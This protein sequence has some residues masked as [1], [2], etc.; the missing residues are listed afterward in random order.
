MIQ[1]V[2]VSEFIQLIN[3][4]VAGEFIVE[5]EVT[6]YKISQNKWIFFNL[7]DEVSCLSCFST[8]FTLKTPLEEGMK[9]R[10]LG[11]PKVHD[12]SGRFSF[13]VQKVELLGEGALQRA[14]L[15]LKQK[16]SS[17]GL[18]DKTRKRPLPPIPER[19]GVIASGDSAA[20]GD[21]KRILSNR[22]GGVEVILRHVA[23]QG[24]SAVREIV[25]AFKDF[26]TSKTMCDVL[27]LIRG[28][29]SLE[30]LMAFNSEE[31][32]RAIYSSRIPV[33]C[34]VGH[35]RDETLADL[36]ADLRASTPSNAAELLVPDRIDFIRRLVFDLDHIQERLTHQVVTKRHLLER[37]VQFM[38]NQ[39]GIHTQTIKQ[40][41]ESFMYS[42]AKLENECLRVK[43][44]LMSSETLFKNVNP[45]Q[46]LK[47][48][49]S[50]TRTKKG[51]LVRGAH[52][53]DKKEVLM[54]EL[55][56]GE[57]EAEVI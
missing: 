23:V 38:I 33:I 25:E 14:Y 10:V 9:V 56:Q 49:F 5:G 2:T 51:E 12:K 55:G 57:I 1:V 6:E 4:V 24:D 30:D 31:V 3:E 18:F 47:R 34:G 29:G 37:S 28:G 11:Y 54:I 43:E 46:L 36:V 15:L 50:I 17:E 48:G 45:K 39:F 19:V 21:F 52:Q 32:V 16:L 41:I 8:V 13:T 35:E 7:K 27:V 42:Q 20:W 40:T 44:F 26:N 22:W 53:V